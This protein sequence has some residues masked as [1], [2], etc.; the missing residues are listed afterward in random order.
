M[1]WHIKFYLIASVSVRVLS[2]KQQKPSLADL[3]RKG[4]YLSITR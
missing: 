4:T 3:S 2:G 1:H